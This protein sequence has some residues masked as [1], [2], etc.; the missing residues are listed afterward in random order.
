MST[1][2]RL[3]LLLMLPLVAGCALSGKL[4]EKP[5]VSLEEVS[6]RDT[7]LTGTTLV[8]RLNL[9]NPNAID[10]PLDDLTYQVFLNGNFFAE[11]RTDKKVRIP[12]RGESDVEIPLAV[13]YTKVL[14]GLG[15][16][17]RGEDMD[18]RLKGDAKFAAFSIP[19]EKAGDLK[20]L[21]K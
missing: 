7:N 21:K 3:A 19:F 16:V 14:S 12:A 17:L 4:L 5:T 20:L 18:Y 1:M 10:L 8:F 6:A 11:G 9:K 13:Q 15:R 2:S